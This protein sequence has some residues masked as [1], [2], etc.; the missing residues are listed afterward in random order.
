MRGKRVRQLQGVIP[1]PQI[2]AHLE[3]CYWPV[4]A[5]EQVLP[6]TVGK[7]YHG[8]SDVPEQDVRSR[9]ETPPVSPSK[10]LGYSGLSARDMRVESIDFQGTRTSEEGSAFV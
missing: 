1:V 5:E 7:S 10:H 2:P 6:I 9:S 8:P 4:A 3:S